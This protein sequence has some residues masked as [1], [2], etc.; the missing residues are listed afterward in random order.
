M[1]LLYLSSI[2]LSTI[3]VVLSFDT[4]NIHYC[5]NGLI[6]ISNFSRIISQHMYLLLLSYMLNI[7]SVILFIQSDSS[8]LMEIFYLLGFSS[9]T[10]ILLFENYKLCVKK[11][12]IYQIC[13]YIDQTGDI[14]SI[15]LENFEQNDVIHIYTCTHIFHSECSIELQKKFTICPLC[16]TLIV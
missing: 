3:A 13:T 16:R 11:Q 8:V 1:I 14:C 7:I 10:T 4:Q 15:C 9:S 5:M 6:I 2:V 12:Y